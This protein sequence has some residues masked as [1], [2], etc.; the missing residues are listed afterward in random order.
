MIIKLIVIVSKTLETICTLT[1]KDIET[2]CAI[3]ITY[4]ILKVGA[5]VHSNSSGK[6][7]SVLFGSL[8]SLLLI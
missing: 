8:V 3:I 2:V 1:Y 5:I 6:V 7:R 4:Q